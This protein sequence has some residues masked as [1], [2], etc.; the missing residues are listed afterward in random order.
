MFM[1]VHVM[2]F[3]FSRDPTFWDSQLLL[4]GHLFAVRTQ[5]VVGEDVDEVDDGVEEVS[6][7]NILLE[8]FNFERDWY[9]GRSTFRV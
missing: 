8:A 6:C 1:F 9:R 5:K 4:A 3:E 7:L 2:L